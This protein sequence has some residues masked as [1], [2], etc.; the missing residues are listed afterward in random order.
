VTLNSER[1]INAP[2]GLNGGKPGKTGRN[3]IIL[4]QKER[5]LSGKESVQVDPG[6]WLIIET[7]GGGGWG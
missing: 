7:P 3:R 2:Y 4:A 1:R 5:K 6:D